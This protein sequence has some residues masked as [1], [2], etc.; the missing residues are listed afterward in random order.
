VSCH[1]LLLLA[2]GAEE[3]ERVRAEADQP[4]RGERG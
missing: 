1:Q 4:D 3:A 2:N